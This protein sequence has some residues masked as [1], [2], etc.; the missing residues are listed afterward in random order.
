METKKARKNKLREEV[1]VYIINWNRQYPIDYWWRKKYNIA[2]G[3]E[4]H[5]QATFIQMYLDFEEEKRMKVIIQKLKEQPEEDE[6]DFENQFNKSGVGKKMSQ[7][8]IDDDFD[9]IDLSRYNT[10]KE[11]KKKDG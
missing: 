4:E 2:F 10:I 9:N 7:E 8:Q 1:S 3:S 6:F 5:R 11:N